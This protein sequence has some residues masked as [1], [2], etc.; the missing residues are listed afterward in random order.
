MPD[1]LVSYGQGL[2]ILAERGADRLAVAHEGREVTRGEL[3]RQSNRL[4]RAY[5]QR[6][7]SQGDFV[8]LALPNSVEFVAATFATWKLGAVPQPISSYLPETER[9]ALIELAKPALLVGVES[10]VSGDRPSLPLGFEPEAELS[11]AGLPDVVSPERQA[12]ASGGSTGRPKLIV[13]VLPAKFDPDEGFYAVEPE[14]MTLIPGPMYHAGPFLN[15]HLNILSGGAAILLTRFDAKRCL[16]LIE[17]YRVQFA[18]L[19]P[20]MLQR[21]WRLPVADRERFD[22]SSLERVVSSGAACPVWLKQEWMGWIG[23]EHFFEAYGA[24]ERIGGTMI[25]GIELQTRPDSVGKPS[26]GRKVRIL[27]DAGI[28]LPPGE[29][30]EVF[31][32]PPGGQGSTY[33]YIGAEPRVAKGGWESLGDMG[34]VDEEGYLYL[35]DRR[36][37]MVVTGGVNVYPAEVEAAIDA[38]PSVHSSVVIGLPDDDLGQRLHALVE[39]RPTVKD[40]ELREFLSERLVR[41]KVPRSF[42]FVDMPLR[43]DAGKVRRSALRDAR[44]GTR[45]RPEMSN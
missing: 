25:S 7:V 21:I 27:D 24:S 14:S 18:N 20:T 36:S 15:A 41:Y 37:D 45:A 12:L 43:D 9:A 42:E 31:M 1:S 44:V 5:A 19:V 29:I 3:D 35:A 8:T 17:R 33:R 22:V 11:D 28:E 23:P 40:D 38:H 34:H 26:A 2:T 39:A 32:K 30:G 4:A 10:G 6:G 16:D 13:D